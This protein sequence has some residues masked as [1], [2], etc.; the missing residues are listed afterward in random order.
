[1]HHQAE[2]SGSPNLSLLHSIEL[3]TLHRGYFESTHIELEVQF[4]GKVIGHPDIVDK[5]F[6]LNLQRCDHAVIVWTL[7]ACQLCS[8]G[9]FSLK[10]S[11][12]NSVSKAS[13]FESLIRS[14]A[15][16]VRSQC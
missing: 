15:S 4:M 7:V 10:I 8:P 9:R 16:H 3:D 6:D 1:M 2:K 5:L 12:R 14:R 13:T 11:Q